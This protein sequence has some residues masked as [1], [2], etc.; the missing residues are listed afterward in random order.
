MKKVQ[1]VNKKEQ[2]KLDYFNASSFNLSN[3]S[4]NFNHVILI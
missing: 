1:E 4:G 3:N 2:L